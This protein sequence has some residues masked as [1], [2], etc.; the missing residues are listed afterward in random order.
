M[1]QIKRLGEDEED[2]ELASANDA[3]DRDDS[4]ANDD[5]DSDDYAHTLGSW[6]H[7]VETKQ[8]KGF[9]TV[10]GRVSQIDTPAGSPSFGLKDS[11]SSVDSFIVHCNVI[12]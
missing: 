7:D 4:E 6:Y 2:F 10:H 1:H 8:G 12:L 11:G 3:A 5:H 9:R